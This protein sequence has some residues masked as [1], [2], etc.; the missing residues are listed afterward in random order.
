[1]KNGLGEV[2]NI[3]LFGT[4][5]EIGNA[6]IESIPQTSDSTVTRIGINSKSDVILDLSKPLSVIEFQAALPSEDIDVAVFA[7]GTMSVN[8]KVCLS[9]ATLEM[10][11]INFNNTALGISLIVDKMISQ[12][13]GTVV[14]LSSMA[15]A[16]PRQS[17]FIYGATK[18]GLDFYVRGLISKFKN[19]NITILL[20]RP[21]FVFT[22]LTSNHSPAPF[23]IS[24]KKLASEISENFF[25]KSKIIYTSKLLGLIYL[26]LKFLPSS[27]VFKIK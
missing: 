27:I 2:Q 11:N 16:R 3:V 8:P 26:V 15:T 22:K 14:V 21:G 23:A 5:S 1:M 18:S 13:H 9:D 17:N 7:S 25:G 24:P 12:G 20:V 19:S 6:I 4:S 10:F